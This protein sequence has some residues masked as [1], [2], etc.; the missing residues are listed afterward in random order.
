[1]KSVAQHKMS[2]GLV[3]S[4]WKLKAVY[5]RDGSNGG[6]S[7]PFTASEKE[8]GKDQDAVRCQPDPTLTTCQM[9][10]DVERPTGTLAR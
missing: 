1:M 8:E 6:N 7:V 2:K 4:L 5:V 9:E 10:G 3:V